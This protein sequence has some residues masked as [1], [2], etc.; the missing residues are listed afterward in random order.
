MDLSKR[1]GSEVATMGD[2][3]DAAFKAH[4]AYLEMATKA[5][6]PSDGEL[7]MLQ[8]P[9]ADKMAEIETFRE[10]GRRCDY[11]T[12]S[13]PSLRAYLHS[14]GS[15]WPPRPPRLSRRCA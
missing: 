2:M 3:V 9:M 15:I 7:P 4:R 1:I 10:K 6:K 12:T 13:P 11:F 14:G 5:K 8:K